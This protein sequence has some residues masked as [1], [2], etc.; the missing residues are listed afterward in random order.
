MEQLKKWGGLG[1]AVVIFLLMDLLNLQGT[2]RLIAWVVL[3]VAGGVVAWQWDKANNR[4]KEDKKDKE[5]KE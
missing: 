4:A 5:D 2:A 1:L 3:G